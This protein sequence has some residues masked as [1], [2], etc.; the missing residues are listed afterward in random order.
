[1]KYLTLFAPGTAE[2]G[3]TTILYKDISE[4]QKHPDATIS[5][6]TQKGVK[7]ESCLPWR[8]NEGTKEELDAL[9]GGHNEATPAPARAGNRSFR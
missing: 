1:M 9:Q 8:I 5:F 7:V 2:T 4:F 3:K 6:K